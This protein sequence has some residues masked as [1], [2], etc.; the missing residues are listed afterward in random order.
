MKVVTDEREMQ[1]GRNKAEGEGLER[2]EE[3]GVPVSPW[4]LIT[5]RL[6]LRLSPRGQ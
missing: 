3:V 5:G 1:G 6:V 2:I 4:E